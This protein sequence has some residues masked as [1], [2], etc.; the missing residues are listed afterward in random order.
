MMN[1][2]HVMKALKVFKTIVFLWVAFGVYTQ[3]YA[4]FSSDVHDQL[5]SA[6]RYQYVVTGYPTVFRTIADVAL[7]A[8]LVFMAVRQWL[9]ENQGY[10]FWIPALSYFILILPDIYVWLWLINYGWAY[11][12]ILA[13]HTLPLLFLLC[14]FANHQTLKPKYIFIT[15]IFLLL[16]GFACDALFIDHSFPA[17]TFEFFEK[18]SLMFYRVIHCLYYA[19]IVVLLTGLAQIINL[20]A[21][22]FIPPALPQEV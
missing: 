16:A 3:L 10:R 8:A 11:R 20:K 6:F 18:N 15:A 12:I 22:A 7:I 4:L 5:N 19:G 9:P 2:G 13:L 14:E 21:A 17:R 1:G